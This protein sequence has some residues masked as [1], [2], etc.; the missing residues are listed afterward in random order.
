MKK[1]LF[2]MT[3]Y[4]MALSAFA[5][6]SGN[7]WSF[8]GG[9]GMNFNT[10]PV[11]YDGLGGYTNEGVSSIS[12]ASN[13]AF[14]FSSDGRTVIT[15]D[16]NYAPNTLIT[17][18]GGDESST[19]S[20]L[21]VPFPNDTNK[22]YIFTAPSVETMRAGTKVKLTYSIF[23]LN[24]NNGFGDISAFNI[25]LLDSS[26][27]KLCAVGNCDGSIFWVLCHRFHSNEFYAYKITSAGIAPPVIT[28]IGTP[29]KA[30]GLGP[31]TIT[32]AS[33]GYMKFSSDAK[34]VGLC[35][36]NPVNTIEI[37]DFNFGTGI[38]SNPIK[39]TFITNPAFDF[40]GSHGPYGC[41][42]S[43]DGSK[44]YVSLFKSGFNT[45]PLNLINYIYQYDLSSKNAN[46]I[47]ASKKIVA[48][49]IPSSV[50]DGFAALQ[51]GPD[52]NMY[53]AL[54]NTGQ[55]PFINQPNLLGLACGYNTGAGANNTQFPSAT[56]SCLFGLPNIVESL[57]Q[58]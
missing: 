7:T 36:Y 29:H 8:G 30:F 14:L 27:E 28:A 39:D 13:G 24:L 50:N 25:P 52:G 56:S 31:D 17:E 15:R 11:T 21:I 53:I 38:L 5:Q 3:V 16:G 9:C 6:K 34:H 55:M 35:I 23:D 44:F 57:V 2:L 43:P 20:A 22:F 45:S 42:F 40:A 32:G 18:L 10:N 12:R 47:I 37:L 46:V 49:H 48:S 1:I 41:S 54:S 58:V 51:N 19:Q 33:I 4:L 26:N